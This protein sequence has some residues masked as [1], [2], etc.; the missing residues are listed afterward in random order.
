M[1][2]IY[3]NRVW[4]QINGIIFLDSPYVKNKMYIAYNMNM[5]PVKLVKKLC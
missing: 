3:T 1:F 2:I 4:N 5:Y